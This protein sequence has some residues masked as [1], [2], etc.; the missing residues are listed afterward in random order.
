MTRKTEFSFPQQL[1][2]HDGAGTSLQ[3]EAAIL[4]VENFVRDVDARPRYA[5]ASFH[6]TVFKFKELVE[7]RLEL[8]MWASAMF[9]E[10]PNKIPYNRR[11][12]GQPAPRSP[13]RGYEHLLDL[14]NVVVPEVAPTWTL[15]SAGVGLMGLPFQALLDWPMGTP[16]GHAFFLDADVNASFREMLQ[17][18]HDDLLTTERSKSVITTRPGGWLSRDVIAVF[19]RDTN[20]DPRRWS[21]FDQIYHCD[22]HGDPEHWGFRSWDEFFT[23]RFRDMDRIR[24][25]AFE[26][27]PEWVVVPCEAK[28]AVIRTNVQAIDQF[29]VKNARYSVYEML[30]HHEL[31]E[32]FIGGTIYQS[33]LLPTAYHRWA[34]PVSGKVISTTILAGAYF[35]ERSTNGLGDEPVTPPLYNL[36]FLSHV[37][38][39]ALVF[40]QADDPI[41]IVCFMAIGIADV[42][43]CEINP[44]FTTGKPEQ[45]RK[46]EELGM[47]RHGGS[48]QCLLFRKGLRLSFAEGAAPGDQQQNVAIRSA[49]AVAHA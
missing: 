36:V 45:V 13:V 12:P 11:R 18:W 6:P 28:A 14:L 32:N 17:A 8:R 24:P 23:R 19:E 22:P 49:L 43:S 34:S 20:L 1:Q 31:T 9:E 5:P 41:G 35:S 47:F 25:I 26:D 4:W 42:S 21:R 44:K 15:A 39:R 38:T 10:V 3:S 30:N 27:S 33:V 40:I 29:W 48:S 37:A 2:G 7:S 46:G 16:S